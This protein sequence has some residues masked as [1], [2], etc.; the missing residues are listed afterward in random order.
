MVSPGLHLTHLTQLSPRLKVREG[1][2]SRQ[3]LVDVSALDDKEA[4]MCK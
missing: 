1:V 3:V 4:V 2:R